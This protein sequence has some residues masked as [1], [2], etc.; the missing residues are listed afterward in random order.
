MQKIIAALDVGSC[1]TRLAVAAEK[2]KG[3]YNLLGLAE[4]PSIEVF[5]GNVGNIEQ[6]AQ[7]IE[8][9]VQRVTA[10]AVDITI[11]EIWVCFNTPRLLAHPTDN[12]ITVNKEN[13]EIDA[14]DLERL[15]QGIQ[16][17][18][19][20]KEGYAIL[21]I[22]PGYYIV[23]ERDR[24]RDPI[25]RSGVRLKAEYLLIMAPYEQTIRPLYRSIVKAGLKPLGFIAH[26]IASA[27]GVLTPSEKHAG[28]CLVDIGKDT[29]KT[30]VYHNGLIQ[31]VAIYP[32]GGQM[33]TSDIQKVFHVLYETAEEV[34]RRY[35]LALHDLVQQ[36]EIIPV[37]DIS[38][39]RQIVR[40]QLANVIEARLQDFF[41]IV[42][43]FLE[44][45]QLYDS[46]IGGIVLTGAT[47]QMEGIAALCELIT[48]KRCRIGKPDHAFEKGLVKEIRCP[49]YAAL[50]GTLLYAA[51]YSKEPYIV[52]IKTKEKVKNRHSFIDTIKSFFTSSELID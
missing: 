6:M 49:S 2:G 30:L 3:K 14:K 41:E 45:H 22:I 13:S 15:H 50:A 34:K 35:G 27:E 32:I 31:K 51:R 28:V 52:S 44:D 33:I 37:R 4:E 26:P 36:D 9:L 11:N 42:L 38:G 43:K 29:L 10:Q 8:R 20:P 25:G 18:K 1:Y 23:D 7:L 16:T 12:L 47:A 5:Q 24:V 17:I 39:E 46:I 48:G 19:P 40:S 21:Q